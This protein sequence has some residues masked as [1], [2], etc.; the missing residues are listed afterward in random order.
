MKMVCTCQFSYDFYILPV[1]GSALKSILAH[2][3]EKL[4]HDFNSIL[5]RSKLRVIEVLS[6]FLVLNSHVKHL[7]MLSFL[8]V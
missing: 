3:C 2:S 6:L 7:H 8:E 1:A 4:N 5:H